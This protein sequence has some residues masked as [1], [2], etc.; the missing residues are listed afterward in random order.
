AE[1]STMRD[2]DGHVEFHDV[3][4]EYNPGVE[5]LKRVSFDAPAGSTTALVGSSGSGKSTLIGLVM[6]FNHP[7]SGRVLV[8]G[9]DLETVRLHDYRSQVGV[10][11]QD[12]FLF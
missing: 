9:R 3:T 2:T 1:K 4:F 10:V 6:A 5:V 11:M 12:N 7:K 8:D